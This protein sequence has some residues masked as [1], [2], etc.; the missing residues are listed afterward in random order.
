MSR[1]LCV[2]FVFL[3][4]CI[5]DESLNCSIHS[6]YRL[7]V[8]GIYI[9]FLLPF[10][11]EL[12]YQIRAEIC[13]GSMDKDQLHC[14]Q[15]NLFRTIWVHIWCNLGECSRRRP[16]QLMDLDIRS[17]SIR[18]RLGQICSRSILGGF[19][20]CFQTRLQTIRLYI[21]DWF[22]KRKYHIT[23]Q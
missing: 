23:N 12:I 2:E 4:E 5:I 6:Q 8:L 20:D 13:F 3:C 16:L 10:I 1:R 9:N 22:L 14:L 19:L 7:Y 21:P 15:K 11:L 17:R 18:T